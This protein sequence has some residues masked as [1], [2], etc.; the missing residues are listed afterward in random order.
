M[1][2]PELGAWLL[3]AA[4]I[5]IF[6]MALVDAA[7]VPSPQPSQRQPFLEEGWPHVLG[8]IAIGFELLWLLGA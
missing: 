2:R 8:P 4:A 1:T 5:L 3:L 6:V 7:D